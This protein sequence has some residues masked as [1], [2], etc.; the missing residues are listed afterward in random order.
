M[1]IVTHTCEN[2]GTI[3]AANELERR[4]VTK[5]AGLGCEAVVRFSDLPRE[6]REHLLEHRDRYSV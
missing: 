3:V 6:D 1:R 4:R 2:C 5:C